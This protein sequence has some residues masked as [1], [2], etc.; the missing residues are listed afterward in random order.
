[1]I[2]SE[3]AEELSSSLRTRGASVEEPSVTQP[4]ISATRGW[5][6]ERPPSPV[7]MSV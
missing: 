4:S 2:A 6:T 1:M 3:M 5:F 7:A